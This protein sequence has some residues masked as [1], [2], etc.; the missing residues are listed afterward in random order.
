MLKKT[1]TAASIATLA[2]AGIAGTMPAAVA[3]DGAKAPYQIAACGPK[4][5]GAGKCGA[6]KCGA[7]KCGAGKCG[8]GKCGAGK[9]GAGKCGGKKKC[10]AN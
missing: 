3:K 9:C 2:G 7:G 10:G 1:L 4:K 5:C 8:A 6:G